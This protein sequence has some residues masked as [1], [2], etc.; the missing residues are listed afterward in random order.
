MNISANRGAL[1]INK[2]VISG[3]PVLYSLLDISYGVKRLN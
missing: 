1:I 2:P 3:N